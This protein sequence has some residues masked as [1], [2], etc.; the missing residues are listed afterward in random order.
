MPT[1]TNQVSNRL[2]LPILTLAIF[3][4]LNTEMAVVGIIPIIADYLNIS[5]P[6][7]GWGTQYSILGALLFAAL[8][9]IGIALR[10]HLYP[11]TMSKV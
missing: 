4:I 10:N 5:V 11:L 9:F 2:L 7:A 1:A 3:G 8:G 6:D